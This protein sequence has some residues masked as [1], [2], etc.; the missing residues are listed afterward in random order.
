[1]S[2]LDADLAA[3]HDDAGDSETAHWTPIFEGLL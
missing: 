3:C 1:M 2:F